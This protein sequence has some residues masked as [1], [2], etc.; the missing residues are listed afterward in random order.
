MNI[1]FRFIKIKAEEK[2]E[3]TMKKNIE[4]TRVLSQI[5]AVLMD[6]EKILKDLSDQS[7]FLENQFIKIAGQLQE[8]EKES[9]ER[10]PDFEVRARSGETRRPNIIPFPGAF[11]RPVSTKITGNQDSSRFQVPILARPGEPL[12]RSIPDFRAPLQRDGLILLSW[13]KRHTE[14]G[15]RYTAYWVTSQGINRYYASDNLD[16]ESFLAAVPIRKSYAAEDGIEFYGQHDLAYIV[17]VAPDLMI[18]NRQAAD[19]RSEHIKTLRT[20]GM[21]ADYSYRFLLTRERKKRRTL[22]S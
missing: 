7:R 12:P 22:V 21:K 15:E 16:A 5:R 3:R 14:A 6:Q 9:P 20:L 10:K 18:S 17:H 11:S 8:I 2:M 4:K 1:I 19:K 13:A